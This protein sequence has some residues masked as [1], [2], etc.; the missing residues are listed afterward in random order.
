MEVPWG[1]VEDEDFLI[2][3]KGDQM[4][5]QFWERLHGLAHRPIG[6]IPQPF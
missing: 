6:L 4:C 2:F 3:R 5:I 1:G